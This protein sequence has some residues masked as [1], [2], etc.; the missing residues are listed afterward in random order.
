MFLRR[1][2]I[3]FERTVVPDRFAGLYSQCAFVAWPLR[4]E[5][6]P[7]AAQGGDVDA[8]TFWSEPRLVGKGV[9]PEAA[10][11][12]LEQILGADVAPNQ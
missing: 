1:C 5:D 7:A 6:I 12:D 10:L 9:T 4:E 2:P 11:A 3:G 8:A